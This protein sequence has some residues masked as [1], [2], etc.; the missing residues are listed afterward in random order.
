MRRMFL[1]ALSLIAFW[2][3]AGAI[4]MRHDREEQAY[5]DLAKKF[6]A[7]VV[8]HIAKSDFAMDGM[9]TLIAPRWVLTAGHI[10]D[11]LTPGD[12]VELGGK[13]YEVEALIQ[14]PN[15]KGVT[16]WEDVKRDIALVRLRTAV[17][18]IKPA[19]LYTGTDEAGMALTIVGMGRHGTGL[20]GPVSDDTIMRAA[21]NRVFKVDGTEIVFRFDA[22]GDPDVTELEGVSGDG[23]SGGP[24]YLERDGTIYVVGVGSAQDA[25]PVD[26]K[27]G[28]YGV[29][30]LYPRVSSFA[31]WI[32]ATLKSR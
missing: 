25:K 24:A 15:W 28:H 8:F 27:L 22:P 11:V 3:P 19:R 18:G 4:V 7:T 17:K 21:T 9:G 32:R 26:K 20:T 2:T 29:L 23:D 30:E 12:K 13:T 16:S 1:A 10:A 5:I 14:Y 31:P 6:P